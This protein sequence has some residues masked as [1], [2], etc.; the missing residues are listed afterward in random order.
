MSS[1]LIFTCEA[2]FDPSSAPASSLEDS[3]TRDAKCARLAPAT[4]APWRKSTEHRYVWFPL[5]WWKKNCNK[6]YRPSKRVKRNL[7]KRIFSTYRLSVL[8]ACPNFCRNKTF[9][10]KKTLIPSIGFLHTSP[11]LSKA[12]YKAQRSG[13]SV[14]N[15]S[16]LGLGISSS[17]STLQ[18]VQPKVPYRNL[19]GKTVVPATKASTITRLAAIFALVNWL[20]QTTQ[21]W[22]PPSKPWIEAQP[23][24]LKRWSL[25]KDN[26]EGI[27][28]CIIY[29]Y[30]YIY[31]VVW[32]IYVGKIYM[33]YVIIILYK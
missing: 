20:N 6:V 3:A 11:E 13:Q 5:T 18:V 4:G 12:Q 10:K 28:K 21:A 27:E 31:I 16:G 29:T 32:K 1:I 8:I 17:C 7:K 25:Q 30:I 19:N 14:V 9:S 2:P 33:Y 23:Q 26:H 15:S 22:A 24:G